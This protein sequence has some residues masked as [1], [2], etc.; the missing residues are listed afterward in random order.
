MLDAGHDLALVLTQPDRPA[1]RGLRPAQSAVKQLALARG[2]DVL[3]PAT[4]R[5]LDV[6]ARVAAARPAFLVVAAY[7][8]LLPQW[9]L[10][11]A[12][13]GALNIHASLLPRWRGAAP[14]QRALLAGDAETGITIM[15]MDAGLDTGPMLAQERIAISAGD[16]A[17]SLHDRLAALGARMIVAALAEAAAERVRAVPQSAQGVTY[18]RKIE[19]RETEIDWRRPASEIE[20]AVRALR[21]VPGAMARLRGETIK[22]WRAAVRGDAGDAGTVLAADAAGV[23]VACG[24]GALLATEL[25][26]A[27]GKR[28]A[29]AEFL[30][31]CAIARGERLQ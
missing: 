21:P 24:E 27:G 15:R 25:Q 11:V 22:I 23:L 6:Q 29:A 18:A 12:P 14:I 26:R 30:R 17:Q 13:G 9:A 19:K 16:D 3:Q 31:G 5:D 28:L 2:L 7:G 10:D 1:G 4:L 8:L 20:R